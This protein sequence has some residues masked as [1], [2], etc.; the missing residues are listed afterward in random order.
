MCFIIQIP[1]SI[2]TTILWRNIRY[3]GCSCEYKKNL[4]IYVKE[5]DIRFLVD[6]HLA[7]PARPLI[8]NWE[9]MKE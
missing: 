7:N 4:E 3:S 1:V 6:I 5:H 8:M 9:R 2:R